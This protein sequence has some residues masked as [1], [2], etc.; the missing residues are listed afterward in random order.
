MPKINIEYNERVFTGRT[1]LA[2]DFTY[3][4]ICKSEPNLTEADRDDIR[5]W[6][7]SNCVLSHKSEWEYIIPLVP[8]DNEFVKRLDIPSKLRDFFYGC[9][10]YAK[11]N[12]KEHGEI[13][14][15]LLL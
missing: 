9:L 10:E 15:R 13:E 2:L 7:E 6:A 3:S 1:R 12:E 14:L 5:V 8:S 11:K 4:E